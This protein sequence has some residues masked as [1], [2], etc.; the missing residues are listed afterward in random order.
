MEKLYSAQEI[1]KLF[2]LKVGRI[3]YW[4]RIGFLTPSVKIGARKYYTSQDLIGLK[5]AKGLLDADL[6]F[7]KVRR[8]VVD[9][10]KISPTLRK[11]PSRLLIPGDEKGV[12]LNR[13]TFLSNPRGQLLIGFSQRDFHRGMKSVNI[14]NT[15]DFEAQFKERGTTGGNPSGIRGST[16]SKEP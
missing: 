7:S 10:K 14:Q 8:I 13:I 15:Q 11:L 16:N 6:P 4:D 2:G 9:V 12:F 5:T 1:Q 3:R